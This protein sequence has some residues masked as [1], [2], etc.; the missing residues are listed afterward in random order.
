MMYFRRLGKG[1][2]G[3][4]P[5]PPIT[6][7]PYIDRDGVTVVSVNAESPGEFPMHLS[8]S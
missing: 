7:P 6:I 5:C 8:E 1:E 3:C 2:A 4:G